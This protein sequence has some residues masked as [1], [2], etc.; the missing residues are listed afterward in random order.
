MEVSRM[1]QFQKNIIINGKLKCETGL[2]IGAAKEALEIGGMDNPVIKD[3]YTGKPIIPGSSIKGKIRSLLELRDK[4]YDSDGTPHSHKE[5]CSDPS[6]KFC[7]VFGSSGDIE[8]GPTRL[9][10]RDSICHDEVETEV[11]AENVINRLTGRAEHPRSQER[12]PAGTEFE[13]EM[14]YGIYDENDY[15]NLKFVFEGAK[16]LEDS[17]LGGSGSR[18]YGKVSFRELRFRVRASAD[19]AKGGDGRRI[20]VDGKESFSVEELLQPPLWGKIEKELRA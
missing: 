6:C 2:H 1:V 5:K 16:L 19:Y 15:P 8:R 13:F 7:I 17:Y 4:K 14:I 11:K 12:V 9:I 3:L 10:V 18:G 20:T